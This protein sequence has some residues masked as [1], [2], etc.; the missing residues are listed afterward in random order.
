M[1]NFR[2]GLY[3]LVILDVKMPE[4]DGFG[5]YEN[6]KKLDDKVIICFLTA[7]DDASQVLVRIEA[8]SFCL[9]SFCESL[10]Y[11]LLLEELVFAFAPNVD[12]GVMV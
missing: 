1:E 3:A 12:V 11:H 7:T 2:T 6:I 9:I 10:Q 4:M 5:L 8:M